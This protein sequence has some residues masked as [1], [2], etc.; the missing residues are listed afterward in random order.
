ML[1]ECKIA[2]VQ[3]E[4][5]KKTQNTRETMLIFI[6]SLKIYIKNRQKQIHGNLH[7]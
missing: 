1:F 5:S 7:A 4:V 3:F 6:N 2:R